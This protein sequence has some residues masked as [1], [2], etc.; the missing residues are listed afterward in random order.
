MNPPLSFFQKTFQIVQDFIFTETPRG[1]HRHVQSPPP[2]EITQEFENQQLGTNTIN[3]SNWE[4]LGAR[5]KASEV[6]VS[7]STPHAHRGKNCA[8][9]LYLAELAQQLNGY[10]HSQEAERR[11]LLAKNETLI[12]EA[13]ST[14]IT[15]LNSKNFF[16][17]YGNLPTIDVPQDELLFEMKHHLLLNH[18]E[19]LNDSEFSDAVRALLITRP[20]LDTPVKLFRY[21]ELQTNYSPLLSPTYQQQLLENKTP[22]TFHP[23]PSCSTGN[24]AAVQLA[25]NESLIEKNTS[26]CPFSLPVTHM[27]PCETTTE[28]DTP[29]CLFSPPQITQTH[30][31]PCEPTS[32]E[33]ISLISSR[34]WPTP[35]PYS[36]SSHKGSPLCG[37]YTKHPNFTNGPR[38]RKLAFYPLLKQ[39]ITKK[40]SASARPA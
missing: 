29:F 7:Q 17:H 31:P 16:L 21:L 30:V 25:I 27:L 28:K 2:L 26:F 37:H 3:N 18:R 14:L 38:T 19:L 32:E 40:N 36:Y 1:R 22:S 12:S 8:A 4:L 35:P 9:Y 5:P 33:N 23:I 15:S 34:Q 11:A 6:T 10:D 24:K 39:N 13:E 20:E